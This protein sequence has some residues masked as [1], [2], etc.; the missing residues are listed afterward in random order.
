[1]KQLIRA[2]IPAAVLVA[3]LGLIL[4]LPQKD[5]LVEASISPDMPT[6]YSLPGWYGQKTQE[7]EAE[8]QILA[9]DTKFSKV[10]YRAAENNDVFGLPRRASSPVIDASIVFSGQDMNASIHRPEL[11]LPSQGFRNL[12]GRPATIELAN[13]KVVPFTRLSS[14]RPLSEKRGDSVRY[15][16]YYVFIGHGHIK[17]THMQRVMQDMY[18]RLFTGTVERWAY[19]QIGSYWGDNVG[20]TEEEADRNL[21][22]LIRELLPRI[23]RWEE[24]ER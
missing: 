13:G 16:H 10:N 22:R 3:M 14:E 17:S 24:M 19:F 4:L 23:I 21:R 7:S 20:M 12:V 9:A 1:M 8:R 11:C 18:D 15:I 5:V 6:G 2:L